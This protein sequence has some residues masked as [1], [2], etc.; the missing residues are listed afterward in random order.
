MIRGERS[1]GATRSEGDAADMRLRDLILALKTQDSS[2][3]AL[4]L[5]IDPTVA[6]EL[7]AY[8]AHRRVDLMDLA[9]HCLEQF[10]SDAADTLWQLGIE[11]HGQVDDDPE[12]AMLGGILRQ[13]VLSRLQ[14]E[15]LIRSEAVVHTVHIGF[16]RSGHPY[17]KA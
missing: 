10:A 5:R 13:A 15:H 9:A 12:A 6:D 16:S 14:R 2:A 7:R 4:L 3:S 17:S 1:R 8:A 11:R